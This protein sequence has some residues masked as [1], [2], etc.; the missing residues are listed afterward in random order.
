MMAAIQAAKGGDTVTLLEQNEKLGKKLYI[1]GKGRCNLTNGAEAEDFFRNVAVNPKFLYSAFY[2]F[3]NNQVMDFFRENGLKLKTERG[4]RIFPESDKAS[5]VTAAL[6]RVLRKEEVK[7]CLR[8]K[9]AELLVQGNDTKPTDLFAHAESDPKKLAKKMQGNENTSMELLAHAAGNSKKSTQKNS[10][11]EPVGKICGV[12]LTDGRTLTADVVIIATGGMSYPSTG[13]QGDGYRLATQ[14][15]HSITDTIPALVPMETEEVAAKQLQ[16]LSLKN[17]SVCLK[18]ENKK[19]Y[20]G[21]GEMLFTHFGVSGPLI[22]T[23]SSAIG[24]YRKKLPLRLFIDLKP[25]LSKEQL[26]RRVLRDFE[27]H[28][29][30]AFRNAIQKLF[31][32]KLIPFIVERSGILADKKACD[33]TKTQ[34]GDFV[35][36]IKALPFEIT[37]FR[38]FSEAIITRGGVSVKEINPQTMES[39]LVRGLY[40]AGEVLDLDAFT[41]GFNLQIAWSTGYLAGISI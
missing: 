3:D 20:E 41:G 7:I 26:E 31:P 32:S 9:V 8:T 40:F 5:D 24:D 10:K 23:A 38:G 12:R 11:K 15:G 27:E 39:K 22:L 28:S 2:A 37:G 34:R 33:I 29:N 6:E 1:T 35:D 30:K 36:L 21:F 19:L 16:G 4:E 18:K 13:S 17:I 25:A 14:V